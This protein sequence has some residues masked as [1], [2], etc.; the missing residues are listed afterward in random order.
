[1]QASEGKKEKR[2]RGRGKVER[3]HEPGKKFVGSVLL[4]FKYSTLQQLATSRVHEEEEE[5]GEEGEEERD[6]GEE[7]CDS[8]VSE[9]DCDKSSE[10]RIT[11]R[12]GGGRGHRNAASFPGQRDGRLSEVQYLHKESEPIYQ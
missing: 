4:R 7:A 12:G 9:A 8:L 11:G 2:G 10:E 3:K 1:M 6:D 5:V